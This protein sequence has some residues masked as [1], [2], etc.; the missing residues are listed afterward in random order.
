[1]GRKDQATALAKWIMK[2]ESLLVQWQEGPSK[3]KGRPVS[4]DSLSKRGLSQPKYTRHL[5]ED[6][7]TGRGYYKTPPHQNRKGEVPFL[8]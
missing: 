3:Y 1:M 5:A 6:K 7:Y 2:R 4:V 8:E